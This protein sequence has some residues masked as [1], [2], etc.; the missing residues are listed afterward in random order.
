M[1]AMEGFSKLINALSPVYWIQNIDFLD[2]AKLHG[3]DQCK[4]LSK[5]KN[6]V[7]PPSLYIVLR[8]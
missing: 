8:V 1:G 7:L 3:V 6:V 5:A 4:S 2:M